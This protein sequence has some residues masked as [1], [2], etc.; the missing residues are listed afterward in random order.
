[1]LRAQMLAEAA[2]AP[3]REICGLLFGL[4]GQTVTAIQS[5]A[6]V[7]ARPADTF[8]I[9]PASLIAAHKAQRSGGPMLIGCYHSHPGGSAEPSSRDGEAALD[10]GKLWL[11]ISADRVRAWHATGAGR[12]EEI[13]L[14][15]TG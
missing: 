13:E 8:E 4:G 1:M 10:K 7:A 5:C 15:C 3:E 6:N 12:F 9:D 11:I 14:E 2:A